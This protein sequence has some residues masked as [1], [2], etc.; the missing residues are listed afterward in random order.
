MTGASS[1]PM[2]AK[3][4]LR[5]NQA[6]GSQLYVFSLTAPEISQLTD[7]SRIS[8][9]ET[10]DLIGYQRPEV[11]QHVQEIVDYLDSDEVI[12]PNPIIIALPA[13]VRFVA[14]RGPNRTSASDVFDVCTGTLEIPLPIA[15]VPQ[16]G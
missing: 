3:R 2:L 4:A 13:T 8:R 12:F 6:P 10:G 16:R 14:S 15:N 9:D 5:L 1:R 7:I 11:R